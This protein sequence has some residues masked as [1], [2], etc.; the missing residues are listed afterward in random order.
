MTKLKVVKF[1]SGKYGVLKETSVF[2]WVTSRTF[3]SNSREY[4]FKAKDWEYIAK[5]GDVELAKQALLSVNP[6]YIEV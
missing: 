3:L 6:S 1:A 4:W 2:G 5:F